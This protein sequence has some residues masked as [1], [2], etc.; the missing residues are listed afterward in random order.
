MG[1]L[2]LPVTPAEILGDRISRVGIMSPPDK[3]LENMG[4]EAMAHAKE[5]ADEAFLRGMAEAA[6]IAATM[7]ERP[8]DNQPEF[9]AVLTV[10]MEIRREIKRKKYAGSADIRP[11]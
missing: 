5:K 2:R 6:D 3:R 11:A 9:S 10:E 8:F 1:G 4:L 7:A